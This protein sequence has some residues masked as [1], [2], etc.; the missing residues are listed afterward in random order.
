MANIKTK[1]YSLEF[2][3][4]KGELETKVFTFK[5][6]GT[7][8]NFYS[9]VM[10]IQKRSSGNAFEVDFATAIEFFPNV[11]GKEQFVIEGISKDIDWKSLLDEF[12]VNDPLAL[13]ILVQ[14]MGFFLYPALKNRMQNVAK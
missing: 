11:I 5:Q 7:A 10:A 8:F 13:Q 12:F 4:I 9:R 14:E 3:N 2:T 1:D 6:F